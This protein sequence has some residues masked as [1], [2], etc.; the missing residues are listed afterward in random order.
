VNIT[1]MRV[2]VQMRELA[3]S[4][5]VLSKRLDELEKKYDKHDKQFMEVF[6]AIRQMMAFPEGKKKR[7]IGFGRGEEG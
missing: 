1:I 7:A 3:A 2:F 5:R 4:S 6:D